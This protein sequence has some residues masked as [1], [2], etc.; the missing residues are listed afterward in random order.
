MAAT[1]TGRKPAA[2]D[3]H[4]PG[5]SHPHWRADPIRSSHR[6]SADGHDGPRVTRI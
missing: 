3:G 6:L 5:P 1:K 4:T 2:K